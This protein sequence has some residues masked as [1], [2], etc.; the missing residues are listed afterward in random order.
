MTHF[1][2]NSANAIVAAM[3][4]DGAADAYIAATED[5]RTEMMLAYLQGQIK[6]TEQMQTMYR[7]NA[8]FRDG[9]RSVVFDLCKHS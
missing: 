3:I 2:E 8:Q 4:A 7:T 1:D 9:F 5:E 6:K